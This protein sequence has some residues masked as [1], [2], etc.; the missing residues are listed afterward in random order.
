MEVCLR[1]MPSWHVVVECCTIGRAA[2]PRNS[3]T[4]N[5]QDH[6][7]SKAA[8][9]R[10]PCCPPKTLCRS[11][12]SCRRDAAFAQNYTGTSAASSTAKNAGQTQGLSM[13]KGQT[14]SKMTG[15]APPSAAS[16]L[17]HQE[18][19]AVPFRP[20]DVPLH[21]VPRVFPFSM[22]HPAHSQLKSFTRRCG[23]RTCCPSH[24]A[25]ASLLA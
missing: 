18:E 12:L 8:T 14:H 15:G 13:T 5:L 11:A 4:F 1:I 9:C 17:L 6:A 20:N 25:I 22:H 2:L 23:Q 7:A 16:P 3:A 19:Q 24:S 10:T 21:D